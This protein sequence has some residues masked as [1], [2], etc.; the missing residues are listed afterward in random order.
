MESWKSL[1]VRERDA[2][3]G[4]VQLATQMHHGIYQPRRTD[5]ISLHEAEQ[6]RKFMESCAALAGDGLLADLED[7]EIAQLVETMPNVRFRSGIAAASDRFLEPVTSGT[8]PDNLGYEMSLLDG[9]GLERF[10]SNVMRRRMAL[11]TDPFSPTERHLAMQA[12]HISP[13]E[14]LIAALMQAPIDAKIVPRNADRRAKV[15]ESRESGAGYSDLAKSLGVSKSTVRS[16]IQ[17][18]FDGKS[19][20][21]RYDEMD[22]ETIMQLFGITSVFMGTRMPLRKQASASDAS[23]DA[24]DDT[25]LQDLLDMVFPSEDTA[26]APGDN[27]IPDEVDAGHSDADGADE[28]ESG[29]LR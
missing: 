8:L 9:G 10:P 29:T 13:A 16:D 1:V 23:D 12:M 19:G 25:E 28:S 22:T 27:A 14:F 17:A 7:E 2:C 4:D 20:I 18:I 6:D 24:T 11:D 21:A 26:A 3:G 5:S 15:A